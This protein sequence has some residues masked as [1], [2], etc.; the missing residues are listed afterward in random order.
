M[1]VLVAQLHYSWE[2]WKGVFLAL[3]FAGLLVVGLLVGPL[4]KQPQAAAAPGDIHKIKHIVIIMQENRSYDSYFGTYPAGNGIPR[5]ANG[6]FAVCVPDPARGACVQPYHDSNDLNGGG[7]H[8]ATNATADI[9]GGR[10]DGFVAQQHHGGR[11]HCASP[12]DPRC[13]S[14][15]QPDVMGYHDAREIP[16]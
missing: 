6:V 14:G 1:I 12:F 11:G 7:P 13:G 16:N 8:G 4:N 15:G 3:Y 10:M 9:N 2:R 5:N